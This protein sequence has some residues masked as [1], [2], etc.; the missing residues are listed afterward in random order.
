MSNSAESLPAAGARGNLTE[1][2]IPKHIGYLAGVM[3]FGFLAMTLGQLVEIFYL[4]MVGKAELAAIAFCFPVVMSLN[5]MTRGIGIGASTLIARSMGEGDREHAALLT[6]HCFL[7][8]LIFTLALAMAGEFWARPLFKLLGA[9]EP[10][11]GLA[12]RYTHI[13]LFGF[14]FMGLAMTSNGM[15]RSFG[16]VRYP[17]YIMAVGPIVQVALGPFLIFGLAGFPELGIEG[18]AW[19]FVVSAGSQCLVAGYWYFIKERLL[20]LTL[21]AIGDSC[22]SILHVGIPAAATNLIQP[23][24]IGVVT[25][26]LAGFGI[27]VVAGFGVASRIEAVVGMVIIGIATSVVPLVGQNWGARQFDRVDRTLKLCYRACFV[28]SVIAATIMWTG[29]PWF[30]RLINEAPDVVEPAVTFLYIIPITIG[31][32]GM[33]TISTHCFNALRKPGPALAISLARLVVVYVPLALAAS[34]IFGYIGVFMA[35][36]ATN[37]IVGIAAVWWNRRV[38]SIEKDAVDVKAEPQYP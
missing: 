28:W 29:A 26:L 7:L 17:G 20:R 34:A 31:F 27:S 14:P 9:T 30:V 10:V 3:I 22:L 11:L 23:L 24:S 36:A 6:S 21:H 32:V 4:G 8:V 38:L 37:V 35:T 16:N 12:S 13:W 18:A 2:S 25:W 15:I 5:A 33:I 19:T 1:G